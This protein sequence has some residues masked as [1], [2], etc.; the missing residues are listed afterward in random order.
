MVHYISRDVEAP[1]PTKEWCYQNFNH[2]LLKIPL[3]QTKKICRPNERQKIIKICEDYP[4]EYSLPLGKCGLRSKTDE[5]KK[6]TS[7]QHLIRPSRHALKPTFLKGKAIF[8]LC[9]LHSALC[10]PNSE[11]SQSSS[12]FI[13]LVIRAYIASLGVTPFLITL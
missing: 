11:F 4:S 7:N 8:S 2:T 9:T 12:L 5:A 1:S 6:Q 13:S 3:H 10:T